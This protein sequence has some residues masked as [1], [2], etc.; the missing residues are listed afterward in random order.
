M[1]LGNSRMILD[2]TVA[3]NWDEIVALVAAAAADAEPGTWIYGRGW[4]QEK[5]DEQPAFLSKVL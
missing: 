5:W 1:S 3:R 2:L 4:H